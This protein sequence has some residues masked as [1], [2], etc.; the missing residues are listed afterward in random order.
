MQATHRFSV[1]QVM[2]Q[3]Q[4][5]LPEWSESLRSIDGV[6]LNVRSAGPGDEAPLERF[7][8]RVTQE[9]LRFRYLGAVRPSAD[10]TDRITR[11]DPARVETLLAFNAAGGNLAAIATVAAE[12]GSTDAEV[13]VLVRSDLKGRGIGWA[14]LD[15]ACRQ[16]AALGFKN[17]V[18]VE[19]SENRSAITLEQELGFT[20]RQHPQDATLTI[21]SK[22]LA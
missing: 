12:P 11:E 16:A 9:D 15:H 19:A 14:M 21:L 5:L 3:P 10:F 1:A 22:A 6:K 18:A 8:E 20:A 17:A 7:F 4:R 2:K 13:A